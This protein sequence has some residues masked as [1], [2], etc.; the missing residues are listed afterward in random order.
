MRFYSPPPLPLSNSSF[1]HAAYSPADHE[2]LIFLDWILTVKHRTLKT[3][4]EDSQIHQA[5]TNKHPNHSR[6]LLLF[7]GGASEAGLLVADWLSLVRF[8]RLG[9][10]SGVEVAVWAELD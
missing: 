1:I 5:F 2:D 7:A 8:V 3:E 9:E 4:N 10:G 6:H